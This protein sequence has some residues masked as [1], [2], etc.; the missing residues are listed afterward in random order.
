MNLSIVL[1]LLPAHF[2]AIWPGDRCR[3]DNEWGTCIKL[4]HC[5]KWMDEIQQW[6]NNLPNS[7]RRRLQN[8]N[9]G[10]VGVDS[11]VC[12]PSSITSNH[13][14]LGIKFSEWNHNRDHSD[15]GEYWNSVSND[16]NNHEV[17]TKVTYEDNSNNDLKK[18]PDISR[19]RN[20]RLL[21]KNCGILEDNRILG[22]NKTALFEMPWMVL[23][24]Y[25]SARGESL[26]CGAT[27][28][29]KWYILTAAHCVTNLRSLT[30]RSV[31][32]GEHDV[33]NDPDC[34]NYDGVMNC[35]PPIKTVTIDRIIPHPGFKDKNSD[36]IALLRLSE[37]A[38]FSSDSVGPICLPTTR[39]LLNE[40]LVGAVGSV[41]GWG[42]AENGVQSPVL[43]RV[44][45]PIVSNSDCQ[46][47]YK[48]R[49]IGENQLCAGGLNNKDSCTGDSGGPL[50]YQG[51]GATGGIRYIQ[52]GVVS[53]GTIQC[54]IGRPGVYTRVSHYMDWI[55]DNIDE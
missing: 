41:V 17:T 9:C 13:D 51:R 48:P 25:D 35:A 38:D 30:I 27:L 34:E 24:S 55:L 10:Y 44:D 14:E 49:T 54:G 31:I 33:R 6:G 53:Y 23:I 5:R 16:H 11:L 42:L 15:S 29:T 45:L 22:G 28:I 52:R 47:V 8:A 39:E 21:P 1:L 20:L 26:S 36:D 12:C 2:S 7:V 50:L 43:L 18:P 32:L 46:D 3:I 19:H 37:P 4:T 40:D